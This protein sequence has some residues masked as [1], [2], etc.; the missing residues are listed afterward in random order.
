M[1]LILMNCAVECV[2]HNHSGSLLAN[3]SRSVIPHKQQYQVHRFHVC[4]SATLSE[5][6]FRIVYVCKLTLPCVHSDFYALKSSPLKPFCTGNVHE[7]CGGTTH[8]L[9]RNSEIKG[10]CH[11]ASIQQK[12]ILRFIQVQN[13]HCQ[14]KEI[15]TTLKKVLI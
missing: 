6:N 4:Q 9:I 8:F 13:P 7:K 5:N 3:P 10:I 15:I 11:H 14:L 1:T 12:Q 2:Y